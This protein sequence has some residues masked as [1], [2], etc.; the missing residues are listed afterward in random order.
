MKKWTSEGTMH[1]YKP[2]TE[3]AGQFWVAKTPLRARQSGGCVMHMH[4]MKKLN[5]EGHTKE[6]EIPTSEGTACI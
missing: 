2:E 1:H 5:Y 3:P 6:R 4:E